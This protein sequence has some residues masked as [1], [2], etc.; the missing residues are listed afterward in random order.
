[1]L[2]DYFCFNMQLQNIKK[3]DSGFIEVTDFVNIIKFMFNIPQHICIRD[4]V[5][6]PTEY[7]G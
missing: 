6:A 5:I 2:T 3:M 7:E 1:M 4:I